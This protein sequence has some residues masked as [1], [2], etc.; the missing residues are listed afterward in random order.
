M[1]IAIKDKATNIGF[2]SNPLKVGQFID[3]IG[4]NVQTNLK[5]NDVESLYSD[6]KGISNANIK[7]YGLN[8]INGQE[9]LTGYLAPNGEDALIPTAGFNNFT[10]IQTVIQQIM[11]AGTNNTSP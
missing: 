2:L 7:S 8:E 5:L 6:T 9:L 11:S 1:A 10:Q 4:N 3:A